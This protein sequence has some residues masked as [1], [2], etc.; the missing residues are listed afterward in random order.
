MIDFSTITA[1]PTP[2][3]DGAE[4]LVSW[5]SSSADGSVFQLYVDRA[6][7]WSGAARFAILPPPGGPTIYQVGVVPAAE[8]HVDYSADLPALQGAGNRALLE[9][10]G[11]AWEES[12]PPG[13]GMAGFRVYGESSPGAGIG[14]GAALDSVPLGVESGSAPGGFGLGGYGAGGYGA[15]GFGVTG[16]HYVWKSGPLA[17]GTWHF[18]VK[19]FDNAGNESTAREYAVTIAGPPG[20]PA[21]DASGLRL[22]VSAYNAATKVATLTWGASPG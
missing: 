20:P 3:V 10:D 8:A 11:G 21:R 6:L 4:T 7:A 13:S 16:G 19:A 17:N 12:S 9:W 14:Y 2:E 5:E 18:G 1:G 15:G 22:R